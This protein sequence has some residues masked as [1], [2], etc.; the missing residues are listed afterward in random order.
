[1]IDCGEPP[2]IDY[3]KIIFASSGHTL[4]SRVRYGCHYGYELIGSEEIICTAESVWTDHPH[5]TGE[6][7][8][9][10]EIYSYKYIFMKLLLDIKLP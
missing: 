6:T 9:Y 2:K 5:C 7:Y 8:F 3:G 10:L 1:M 4:A